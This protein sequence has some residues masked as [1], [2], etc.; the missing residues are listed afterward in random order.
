[1]SLPAQSNADAREQHQVRDAYGIAFLL[2]LVS[3]LTGGGDRTSIGIVLW[4]ALTLATL[5]AIVRR[6]VTYRRV[7]LQLVLGLLTIHLL[8]GLSFG[9][10][11]LL[12]ES[13]GIAAFAQGSQGLSGCLYF[14]YVTLSTLGYG[15]ISPVSYVV[16]ALSVAEATIGQIYL[17]SVVAFAVGRLGGSIV[18]SPEEGA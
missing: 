6:L 18:R 13:R 7:N 14:S 8:I 11:Y 12:V 5:V 3:T 2:V 16:R 9:L 17:V 15:D 1:M 4:L 10:G